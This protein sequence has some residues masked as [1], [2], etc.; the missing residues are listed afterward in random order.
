M[1]ECLPRVTSA[2]WKYRSRT[3]PLRLEKC[4]TIME[5]MYRP[6]ILLHDMAAANL[7]PIF[8]WWDPDVYMDIHRRDIRRLRR[9]T[10]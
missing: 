1:T 10:S 7:R 2:G 4:V 9:L 3:P 6:R 5:R 8:D